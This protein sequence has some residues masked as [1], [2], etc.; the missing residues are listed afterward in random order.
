MK[1]TPDQEKCVFTKNTNILVSAGAG[2]GKTAVLTARTINNLNNFQLDEMI[3]LTFTKAAAF[4]MKEKI[5]KALKD[6]KDYKSLKKI[7]TAYICTF[8]SF[9]LDLVK[10]YS[11]LLN[12]DANINI[13]DN[14]IISKLKKDIVDEVFLEFYQNQEFLNLIDTFT[15]KDDKSIKNDVLDILKNIDK[16]YDPIDYLNN[17][18]V[19]NQ[20]IDELLWGKT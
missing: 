4:S 17:Y 3:I 8:D 19:N 10:K 15:V 16:I 1:L 13:T 14:V 9:S 11:H 6:K 2:S 12:I 18:K 7:D 20:F 5:R